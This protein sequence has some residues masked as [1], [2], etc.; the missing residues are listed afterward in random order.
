MAALNNDARDI[1]QPGNISVQSQQ[2]TIS[3]RNSV[4]FP[5]C[6]RMRMTLHLRRVGFLE[7][8]RNYNC[9]NEFCNITIKVKVDLN[10][11]IITVFRC[12]YLNGHPAVLFEAEMFCFRVPST[13]LHEILATR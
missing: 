6:E 2:G 1:W 12:Y 7:F 3:K 9:I 13:L 11:A 5:D 8:V 10:C 4:S